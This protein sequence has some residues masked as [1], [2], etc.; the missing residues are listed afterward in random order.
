MLRF[1]PASE[2]AQRILA[3]ALALILAGGFWEGRLEGSPPPEAARKVYTTLPKPGQKVALDPD[4]YFI[5]GFTKQPKLGMAVMRVEVFR[6]GGQRDTSYTVKGDLDMPSMRGAHSSGDRP[7]ACSK[8]GVYLLPVSLVMPGDWE[9][10]FTF[11]K[12]GFAGFH[13]AYLFDL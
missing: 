3:G 11:E 4:T 13:G 10:R 5:Y 8:Q 1:K 2:T 6:K 12:K 7:F 9:L